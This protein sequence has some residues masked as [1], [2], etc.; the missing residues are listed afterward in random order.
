ME[1]WYTSNGFLRD[2]PLTSLGRW[3]G[4]NPFRNP[5][6]YFFH[7]D[8]PGPLVSTRTRNVRFRSMI[9]PV[10]QMGDRK[11]VPNADPM[12]VRNVV[13]IPLRPS[14][15]PSSAV[16]DVPV[17]V[18]QGRTGFTDPDGSY[19]L[20]GRTQADGLRNVFWLGTGRHLLRQF[21]TIR[22]MAVFNPI[23]MGSRGYSNHLGIPIRVLM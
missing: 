2:G 9:P 12:A 10:R 18:H 13:I 20:Y 8:S 21:Q 17:R 11:Y 23:R 15:D 14:S 1:E 5:L 3:S 6:I 4:R 22:H 7:S 19:A 16:V